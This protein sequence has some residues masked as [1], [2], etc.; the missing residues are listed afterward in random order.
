MDENSVVLYHR[1]MA[2]KKP[3]QA[4]P[5]EPYA[6][7]KKFPDGW[8]YRLGS[9][10][11]YPWLGPFLTQHVAERVR[12]G[13]TGGSWGKPRT[14]SGSGRA[15]ATLKTEHGLVLQ[16]DMDKAC[17]GGVTHIDDKGFA[18]C[19]KHGTQRQRSGYGRCRKLRPSEIKKL[20]RGETITYS[21]TSGTRRPSH[22]ARKSAT[23]T[24]TKTTTKKT[25]RRGAP[26]FEKFDERHGDDWFPLWKFREMVVDG[27]IFDED[28]SGRYGK[29]DGE[30]RMVSNVKVD[31][32]SFGNYR[33]FDRR[34][35]SWAK[36]VV[37]RDK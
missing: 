37:W 26:K 14:Q 7:V 34:V 15:H 31:L 18:Y 24:K 28:G 2:Q 4:W 33:E 8:Y 19:T 16:C 17:E 21:G 9:S 5:S 6:L 30:Q 13:A 35:P 11:A 23:K 1:H 36:S 10:S 25:T 22:A 27:R 29:L 3:S 20:E 32:S 12:E